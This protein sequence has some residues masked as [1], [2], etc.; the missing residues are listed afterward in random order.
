M[1]NVKVNDLM[2]A[3]VMTTTPS[4]TL[5]HVREVMAKHKV[6]SIPVVG[7]DGEAIGIVTA[8]DLLD[9]PAEGAPVSSVMSKK[10]YVVP[11][12]ADP[13]TAARVM[14]N[15]HIH[16]VIVTHEKRIVG[17]LSA[18]DL[19]QLV[20]DHRFTMKNPPTPSKRRFTRRSGGDRAAEV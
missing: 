15:H 14:R 18:Y 8:T 12:Y 16:H 13:S 19:L 9:D 7:P 1:V 10:V 11:Q 3:G 4:Q 2:V 6:S 5:G 17:I 20:E